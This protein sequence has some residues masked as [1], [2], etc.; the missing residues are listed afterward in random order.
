MPLTE[1]QE[2]SLT[3]GADCNLHYH[4][5]DRDISHDQVLQF[6]ASENMRTVTASGAITYNDDILLV[7]TTS[8]AVTLALPIARGGKSYSV[9]RIAGANAVTL[10]PAAGNTINLTSSV[11]ISTNFA[12][13]RIKALKGTGWFQ[14]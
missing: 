11:S 3:Q 9:V 7:N 6:Q 14:V 5:T 2:Q 12:P 8:G 4:S 13:V 1:D 10:T